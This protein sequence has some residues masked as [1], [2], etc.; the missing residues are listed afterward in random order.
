MNGQFY[1]NEKFSMLSYDVDKMEC[2][3]KDLILK[4]QNIPHTDTVVSYPKG[5]QS[6]FSEHG[7]KQMLYWDCGNL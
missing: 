5:E 3:A 2:N 4:R 7:E 1:S 6:A